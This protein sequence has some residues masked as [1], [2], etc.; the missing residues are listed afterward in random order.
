MEGAG[1][2]VFNWMEDK[3]DRE[4]LGIHKEQRED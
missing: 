1:E 2:E 4:E 3:I